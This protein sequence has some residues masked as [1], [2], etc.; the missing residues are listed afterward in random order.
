MQ[1]RARPGLL[2]Q[3]QQRNLQNSLVNSI[4]KVEGVY[5][6]HLKMYD[7]MFHLSKGNPLDVIVHEGKAHLEGTKKALKARL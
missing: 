7:K 2:L 3:D 1:G 5:K 4:N 6:Q